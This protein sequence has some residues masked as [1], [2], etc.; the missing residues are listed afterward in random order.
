M[1]RRVFKMPMTSR[2]AAA[3]MRAAKAACFTT[4]TFE[5]KEGFKVTA[6]DKMVGNTEIDDDE[7]NLMERL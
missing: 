6:T 2:E 7:N 4:I 3:F 1:S 5:T